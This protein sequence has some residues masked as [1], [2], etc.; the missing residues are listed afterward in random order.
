MQRVH[1]RHGDSTEHSHGC[2]GAV[3]RFSTAFTQAQRCC[4]VDSPLPSRDCKVGARDSATYRARL[5]Q[6]SNAN[7]LRIQREHDDAV[8]QHRGG[9]TRLHGWYHAIRKVGALDY[10][11]GCTQARWWCSAIHLRIALAA[12]AGSR[13]SPTYCTRPQRWSHATTVVVSR[14]RISTMAPV[15]G[16]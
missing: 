5:Q 8:R 15:I 4:Q 16:R 7:A 6:W 10:T 2:S 13:E 3:S 9:L 12:V 14:D 11:S 1:D